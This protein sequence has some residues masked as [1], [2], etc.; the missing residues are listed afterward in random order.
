MS[1]NATPEDAH[2]FLMQEVYVPVFLEKLASDYGIVPQTEEEVAQLL[3]IASSITSIQEQ[4]LA[5]QAS[6]HSSLITAAAQN[7]EGVLNPSSLGNEAQVK[8]A[9]Q[10]SLVKAAAANLALN[11]NVREAVAV[12][13]QAIAEHL[14]AN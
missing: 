14:A 10:E 2:A 13:H 9:Q 5:K 1:T 7:L 12:Y 11:P 8:A 4:E 6:A 3:K